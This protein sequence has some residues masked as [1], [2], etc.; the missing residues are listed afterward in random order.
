MI[1]P[2]EWSLARFV[3][4]PPH[5]QAKKKSQ[6]GGAEDEWPRNGN[7]DPGEDNET[8]GHNGA[9]AGT[10]NAQAAVSSDETWFA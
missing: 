6:A 4:S 7:R 9:S 3:V 8:D 5:E 1:D 2:S 10:W